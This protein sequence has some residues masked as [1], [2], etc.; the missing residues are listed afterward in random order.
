M[1]KYSPPP[2]SDQQEDFFMPPP[3]VS[4]LECQ[5]IRTHLECVLSVM[6]ASR[7]VLFDINVG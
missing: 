4:A 2:P 3:P 6:L 7:L 5:R 1:N